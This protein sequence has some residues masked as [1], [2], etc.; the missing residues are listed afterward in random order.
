MNRIE[1]L[2]DFLQKSPNDNFLKHALALEY[3]KIEDY[4]A[5]RQLFEDILTKDPSYV[6]SYYQL[7]KLLEEL[8]EKDLATDWYQKGMMAAKS[9]KDNHAYNELQSA[10]EDLA[11]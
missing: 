6:G 2:Q 5:A 1:K 11:D 7:G 3:K 10:Y 8:G 9:A 4:T